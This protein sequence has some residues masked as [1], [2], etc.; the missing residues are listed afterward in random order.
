MQ[1]RGR[2][3]LHIWEI[4]VDDLVW[5]IKVHIFLLSRRLGADIFLAILLPAIYLYHRHN[6][7]KNFYSYA[8]SQGH[9]S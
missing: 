6:S 1:N 2:T 9:P 4:P 3:Q 8:V 5:G 7:Y